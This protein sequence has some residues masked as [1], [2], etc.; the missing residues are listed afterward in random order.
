MKEVHTE[1]KYDSPKKFF[2][3]LSFKKAAFSH[4][5]LMR[6]EID[7]LSRVGRFY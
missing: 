5:R 6:E 2:A 3:R 4:S 1:N 7:D